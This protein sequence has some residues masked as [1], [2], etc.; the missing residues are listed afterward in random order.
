MEYDKSVEILTNFQYQASLHKRNAPFP[1]EQFLVTVLGRLILMAHT[2]A[3]LFCP[4]NSCTYN[5]HINTTQAF[6]LKPLL[7]VQI[8]KHFNS[9]FVLVAQSHTQ[10]T[11]PHRWY[12]CHRPLLPKL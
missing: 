10:D 4:H 2:N 8:A 12:C 11:S 1:S 6:L 9:I 5:S 3:Y 7:V